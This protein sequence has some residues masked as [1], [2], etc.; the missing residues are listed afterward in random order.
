MKHQLERSLLWCGA[1]GAFVAHMFWRSTISLTI[2][3]HSDRPPYAA[4]IAAVETSQRTERP[5]KRHPMA[6]MLF[7]APAIASLW[8]PA[9]AIVPFDIR[10]ESE[11]PGMQTTSATFDSGGVETFDA[12]R[13]RSGQKLV[14]DFGTNGDI[15]GT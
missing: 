15:N 9:R 11:K 6:N 8:L 5:K 13:T 2:G 12:A 14:T 10:I 3:R 7:C 1:G 4:L